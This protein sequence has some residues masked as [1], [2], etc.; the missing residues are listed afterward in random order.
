LAI[1]G[2]EKR[3][4]QRREKIRKRRT[5]PRDV[6]VLLETGF[7]SKF[8]L[9]ISLKL[10]V[11]WKKCNTLTGVES[12]RGQGSNPKPRDPGF[13][14][15]LRTKISLADGFTGQKFGSRA[16]KGDTSCFQNKSVM[17]DAE[18]HLCILFN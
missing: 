2:R 11:G 9:S 5:T 7:L 16:V 6:N 13:R 15:E 14:L 17:G 12:P 10:A 8:S 18:G 4:A 1:A 3:E